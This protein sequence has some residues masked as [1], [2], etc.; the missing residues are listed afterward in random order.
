MKK[1]LIEISLI[2]ISIFSSIFWIEFSFDKKMQVDSY[3]YLQIADQIDNFDWRNVDINTTIYTPGYSIFILIFRQFI[4]LNGIIYIQVLIS[5]LGFYFVYKLLSFFVKQQLAWLTTAILVFDPQIINYQTVIL[6]DTLGWFVLTINLWIHCQLIKKFSLR[7]LILSIV[8]GVLLMLT[9]SIF[10]YLPIFLFGIQFFISRRRVYLV[11]VIVTLFLIIGYQAQNYR[12]Y[13]F[14][15]V[16]QVSQINLLGKF[17]EYGYLDQKYSSPIPPELKRIQLGYQQNF[18]EKSPYTILKNTYNDNTSREIAMNGLA[19]TNA[20]LMKTHLIDYLKKV[21]IQTKT[22]FTINR[23]YH[24]SLNFESYPKIKS[25]INAFFINLNHWKFI[26]FIISIFTWLYLFTQ[27]RRPYYYFLGIMIF[28]IV[29]ILLILTAINYGD[30]AR[31]RLSVEWL[32]NSMVILPIIY[33]VEKGILW[34]KKH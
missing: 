18:Q 1:L 33:I 13:S 31:I 30:Y 14:W 9:R 26:F 23:I 6:S 5:A 34:L 32:L 29:Y 27:K 25:F 12:R 7:K 28:V 20:F 24:G 15:G 22:N 17:V 3:Q 10:F 11:A 2:I 8:Y 21:I 4:G 19:K 16:S